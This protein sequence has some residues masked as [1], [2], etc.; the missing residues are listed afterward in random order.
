MTAPLLAISRHRLAVDGNG[1]TTLVC[2]HG[3]PLRCHY[4]L[5]SECWDPSR[6]WRVVSPEELLSLTIIDDL[7]FQAT[8]GGIC[9]GGGE[10]LLHSAFIRDF[11]LQ[12]P[13]E[14][15]IYLESSLHVENHHLQAV[16]PFITHYYIDVKDMNPDIYRRYTSIDNHRVLENLQWLAAHIDLDKVTIRLPHIPGYNTACDIAH[17]RKQ[18]E[19]MGFEDF[20][21]FQYIIP[22][23]AR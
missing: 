6:V 22:N 11:C 21:D 7:Y 12:C 5:N 13:P 15:T 9:F 1:V 2:F 23:E 3:C 8:G 16:A 18:L 10:P 4:C 19:G 14:W 17:S 20:D